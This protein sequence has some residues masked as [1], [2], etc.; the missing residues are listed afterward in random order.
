MPEPEEVLLIDLSS[1]AH[2][3]WHMSSGEPDPNATSTKI[4]ARVRAL[5]AGRKYVAVCCD[6]GR[7][8]RADIADTYKANRPATDEPFRHQ[9]LLARE[10]LLEDGLPVWAVKGFEADDLIASTVHVLDHQG[11]V[12]NA[13]P[14]PVLIVSA[15]KDLLQL[16]SDDRLVRVKS[17]TSDTIFDAAGVVAKFGVEPAQMLDFLTLVGDASDNIQGCKGV[18]AKTAADILQRY[19]TLQDLYNLLDAGVPHIPKEHLGLSVREKLIEFRPQVPLTQSLIRLRE[20]VELPI[21]ELFEE[22]VS[23]AAEEFEAAEGDPMAKDIKEMWPDQAPVP[24]VGGDSP[25]PL[26]AVAPPVTPALP[27]DA[28]QHPDAQ[29]HLAT[30]AL[31][32]PQTAL[33]RALPVIEGEVV[34]Y[35]RQLDPRNLNEAKNL[36]LILHQS[37]MFSG[38]GS[39]QAVMSTAMVGRELGMPIMASLRGIHNIENKHALSAQTMY[40]LILKSGLAEYFRPV[41]FDAT[42]ATFETKR[43]GEGNKHVELQHTMAMAEAAGL[44]KPGS[45][46]VK[47]PV[48]Q[49]IARATSRLARLIYPDVVGGFYTPDELREAADEVRG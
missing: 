12:A 41:S 15:D 47:N 27:T 3:I 6:S 25:I 2:P 43:R 7:S 18:G 33:E 24:G 26:A 9:V 8:F 11:Q 5:A 20:D 14:P 10:R 39:A 31:P 4:V 17:L 19:G 37:K 21:A 40:A 36:S 45:G 32:P 30:G 16:V 49:L 29:R 38:Y 13:P 23:K 34:E 48:D 22:R 44:V 28:L 42:Q 1:I 46:Y 35:E